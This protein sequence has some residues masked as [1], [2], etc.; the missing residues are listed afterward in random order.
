M[1]RTSR[2]SSGDTGRRHHIGAVPEWMPVW[3]ADGTIGRTRTSPVQLADRSLAQLEALLPQL[4]TEMAEA[5]AELEFEQAGYLRDDA[6]A[7]RA[8]IARRAG[9]D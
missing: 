8:E 1:A 3:R 9:S 6:D 4:E 5:V 2:R 7:V